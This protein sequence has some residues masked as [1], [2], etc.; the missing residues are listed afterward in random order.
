[1]CFLKGVG[2]FSEYDVEE[3]T[4]LQTLKG[5]KE[6][7]ISAYFFDTLFHKLDTYISKDNPYFIFCILQLDKKDT[8]KSTTYGFNHTLKFIVDFLKKFF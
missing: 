1:M 5:Y 7:S 8:G 2:Y 6:F 4:H 3:K